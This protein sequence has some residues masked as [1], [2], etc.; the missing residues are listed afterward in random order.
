MFFSLGCSFVSLGNSHSLLLLYLLLLSGKKQNRFLIVVVIVVTILVAIA[1]L[2]V[3]INFQHPED[4]NQAWFPKIIVISGLTIA[5]GAI[6]LLP[7]DVANRASCDASVSLSACETTL[8]MDEIWY[9]IYIITLVYVAILIP[10]TTF[11]YESDFDATLSQKLYNSLFWVVMSAIFVSL[12]LFLCWYYTGY[13]D[14]SI[15][16]VK[17]GM[18][19]LSQFD[20]LQGV[21]SCIRANPYPD[22]SNTYSP[23]DF[24]GGTSSPY[25]SGDACDSGS[26][27]AITKSWTLDVSF[28]AYVAALT[29]F[30][31]WFLFA[32]YAGIGMAANP[33]DAVTRF[34]QRPR[35]TI[36]KSEY[37]RSAQQI[38]IKTLEIHEKVK[39]VRNEERS[40]GRSRKI[41]SELKN[42]SMELEDI[43]DEER[44]LQKLYPR[45]EN[46]ATSW[47]FTV[48]GYWWSLFYG[49]LAFIL[50]ITWILH[51]GLY[52]LAKNPVHPFLNSMFEALDSVFNLFG[53]AMFAIYCFYLISCV[54]KGNEKLG[55]KFLFVFNAYRMKLGAT[56]MTGLLF[57]TGLI[58]LCSMAVAQFCSRAFAS[59]AKDTSAIKML[60]VNADHLQNIGVMFRKDVFPAIFVAFSCASMVFYFVLKGYFGWFTKQTKGRLNKAELKRRGQRIQAAMGR[61]KIRRKDGERS[62]PGTSGSA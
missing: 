60:S 29:S 53:T 48:W 56:T 45:G 8:P 16:S 17:S 50:S 46:R 26:S 3:L 43:E 24:S 6:L 5:S 62:I 10:F 40:N 59:Y 25:L 2:Y 39:A 61:L 55:L 34:I 13:A 44:E 9:S 33:I 42:L 7:L 58:M 12:V 52:I 35:K 31:G 54:V 18:M 51:V 19:L 32:P 20:T 47:T 22:G 37:D 36:G 28:P 38:A 27:E 23:T 57:N 14:F 41:R 21:H 49:I 30:V 1:N 4:R 11:W 15:T